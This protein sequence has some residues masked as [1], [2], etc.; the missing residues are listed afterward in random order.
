[1]YYHFAY[2]GAYHISTTA[3]HPSIHR[4]PILLFHAR[5]F[6]IPFNPF[7]TFGGREHDPAASSFDSRSKTREASFQPDRDQTRSQC[8]ASE[9]I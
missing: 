1:M 5:Y 6:V 2:P 4:R 3:L 7:P 8:G 9:D